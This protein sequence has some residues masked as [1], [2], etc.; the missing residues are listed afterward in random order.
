VDITQKP[1]APDGLKPDGD[2]YGSADAAPIFRWAFGSSDS[3]AYQAESRVQ[4]SETEGDYSI[5]AY[6]SGWLSNDAT[7]WDSSLDAT[8]PPALTNLQ[9][10]YW[11]AA[12]RDQNGEESPYSDEATFKHVGTGDVQITDPAVDNDDTEDNTPTITWYTDDLE[13]RQVRV[14]V[15]SCVA[16]GGN[17]KDALLFERPWTTATQDDLDDGFPIGYDSYTIPSSVPSRRGVGDPIVAEAS[18]TYAVEVAVRD[19]Y[20]RRDEDH[21][22]DTRYFEFVPGSAI[23]QATAL[24]ASIVQAHVALTWTRA[25]EPDFYLIT[26]NGRVIETVDGSDAFVSGTSYAYD[27]YTAAPGTA[28]TYDVVSKE[29][30]STRSAAATVAITPAPVAVWLTDPDNGV[31]VAI[32]GDSDIGQQLSEISTSLAALNRRDAVR[33]VSRIGGY[34]GAVSGTIAV[35]QG[36]SSA[37]ALASLE[38]IFGTR[39]TARLRL[40]FGSRNIPVN[41]GGLSVSQEPSQAGASALYNVSFSYWQI[42]G[43]SVEVN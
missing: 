40:L 16:G 3:N 17:T 24:A 12:V 29:G 31:D 13:Q 9:S 7:Y 15:Y 22:S 23:A 5:L 2:G 39:S 25:S 18:A 32:L 33:I 10:Y 4:V 28:Y 27:D 43:Y 6:D 36:V 37:A 14:R 21:V 20:A 42:G 35:W 19:Q 38:D 26:R 30:A 8:A 34:E 1:D 41:V 11:R